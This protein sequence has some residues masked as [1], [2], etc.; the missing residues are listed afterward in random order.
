[1]IQSSMVPILLQLSL[2]KNLTRAATIT[3]LVE[4][5]DTDCEFKGSYPGGTGIE[6]KNI[7]QDGQ[8]L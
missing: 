6:R 3:P 2:G 4:Q 1:M 5:A 8:R 7:I